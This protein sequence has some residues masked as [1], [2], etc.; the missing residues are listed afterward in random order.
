[1]RNFCLLPPF[2]S[3]ASILAKLYFHPPKT[4]DKHEEERK[5]LIGLSVLTVLKNR[6]EKCHLCQFGSKQFYREA[7]DIFES[8]IKE[9]IDVLPEELRN[10][11]L[12]EIGELPI[13]KGILVSKDKNNELIENT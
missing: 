9:R 6:H 4:L 12:F 3:R 11:I 1:M 10:F 8:L 7:T 5:F 2:L 13:F